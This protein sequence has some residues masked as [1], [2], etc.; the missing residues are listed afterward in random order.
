[1]IKRWITPKVEEQAEPTGFDSYDLRL[2]DIMRGERATLGKSLL[3][4]QRELK[5]KATYIAAIENAD[6]SAFETQGFI[7]GYVRSY[8]RYL[9]MD[10]DAAYQSFCAEAGFTTAHGLSEAA[11]TT[12]PARKEYTGDPLANPDASFVPQRE[13]VFA[14]IE[15]GA[16]GSVAVLLALIGV[17]GY[18]GWSVMQEIQRVDFAPVEQTARSAGRAHSGS[19]GPS[20]APGGSG[21]AGAGA[22]GWTDCHAGPACGR[23]DGFCFPGGAFG[24]VCLASAWDGGARNGVARCHRQRR[25]RGAASHADLA[26]GSGGRGARG[27][28][29][30]HQ[31]RLGPCPC[32]RWHRDL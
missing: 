11:S 25:G 22:A 26:R 18:G 31:R 4:V 32:R 17:I 16:V 14:G 3:D 27:G 2:G 24:R 8:A 9:G 12:K 20:V 30:R 21:R 28:P 29:V 6:V 5:I 10:P 7:A 1:M 23:R 19:A 15:P 13:S